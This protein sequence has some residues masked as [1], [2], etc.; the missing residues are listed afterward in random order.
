MME[1]LGM[2]LRKLWNENIAYY[3]KIYE[4]RKRSGI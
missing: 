4:Y 2:L 1:K 3:G